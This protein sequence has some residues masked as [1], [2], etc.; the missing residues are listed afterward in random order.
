MLKAAAAAALTLALTGPAASAD[1]RANHWTTVIKLHR[2][3]FQACKV[4]TTQHGPWKIR[5]RVDARR[6]TT[7]VRGKGEVDKGQQVVDGPRRT[8]LLQ[9]GDV[10][11]THTLRMPRGSAF[12]FQA[13]LDSDTTGV[14]SAGSASGISRC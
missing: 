10:S 14:A 13:A 8:G 6:A 1:A 2:A 12:T 5:F 11:G 9:P 3:K 7:S 4:P